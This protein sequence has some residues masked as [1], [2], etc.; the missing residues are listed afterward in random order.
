MLDQ[1]GWDGVLSPGLRR[2]R[3]VVWRNWQALRAPKSY[4][5][6]MSRSTETRAKTR[7]LP[8]DVEIPYLGFGTYLIGNDEVAT[9]VSAA[10]RA[11]YRHIDTA[12]AYQ[13]ES[14]VGAAIHDHDM[15]WAMGDPTKA[16]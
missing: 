3:Q 6:H 1:P 2:I 12:E 8:E 9:A 10:I 15:A 4:G 5:L 13:N 14:G 11:G 16:P 7:T